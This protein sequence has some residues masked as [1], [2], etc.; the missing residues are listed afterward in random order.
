M[1]NAL[2]E[3]SESKGQLAHLHLATPFGELRLGKPA[4]PSTT[5]KVVARSEARRRGR[6]QA[7]EGGVARTA[8]PSDTVCGFPQASRVWPRGTRYATG[9]AWPPPR[10]CT[11]RGRPRRVLRVISSTAQ[12][13]RRGGA[14]G[15]R[16]TAA[17]IAVR[18]A[19]TTSLAPANPQRRLGRRRAGSP[20]DGPCRRGT[21]TSTVARLRG[22]P[23]PRP[24]GSPSLMK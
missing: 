18:L 8:R 23:S 2:S 6:P 16:G 21:G 4:S 12:T 5:A 10:R 3:R 7:R 24:A 11:S 14:P 19:G 9:L 22:R 17:A 13:P 20:C 15:P 1:E